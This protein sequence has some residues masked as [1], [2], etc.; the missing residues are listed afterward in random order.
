[1][2]DHPFDFDEIRVHSRR[3]ESREAFAENLRDDLGENIIVTD[4]WRGCL[5][6][7]DIQVEA[8]RLSESTPLFESA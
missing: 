7:A 8:S 5:E 6:G 2:L 1:M 4:N 3:P